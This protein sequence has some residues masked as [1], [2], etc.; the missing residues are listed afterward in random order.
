MERHYCGT[1]IHGTIGDNTCSVEHPAG[2]KDLSHIPG[3]GQLLIAEDSC[4]A[5][6]VAGKCGHV[7]NALWSLSV[8]SSKELTRILTSPKLKSVSSPHWNRNIK[9]SSY[10]TANVNELYNSADQTRDSQDPVAV[11][12]YLGP[13]KQTNRFVKEEDPMCYNKRA[14]GDQC[15]TT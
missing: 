9:G 12:G 4:D 3:H 14:K 7:N 15:F 10:L 11:F 13:I 1:N 5:H 8:D 6:S 2:P